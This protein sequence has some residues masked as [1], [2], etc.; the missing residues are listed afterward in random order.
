MENKPI[1]TAIQTALESQDLI[2]RERVR[3]WISRAPDVETLALLYQL[4]NEA[5]N[6]IVPELQRDE[7]CALIRDYL[8]RC[9]LENSEDDVA[10]SR[11]EA[12]GELEL[13]FDYL[14]DQPST[15]DI[16]KGVAEAITKLFLRSNDGVQRAIETGFLEHILEQERLRHYFSHWAEN[17]RL[18]ETWQCALAWAEAHPN[19]MKNLRRQLRELPSGS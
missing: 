13:W 14:S 17:E 16:L 18:C 15:E 10:L 4:T 2:S 3:E 6:R 9:I 19:Y 11:Y 1:K 5:W 7:T 8:L 12:A